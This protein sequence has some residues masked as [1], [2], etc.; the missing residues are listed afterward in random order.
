M[1]DLIF[2][3]QTVKD[4]FLHTWFY[5]LI[6]IPLAVAVQLSG[7]SRY[8]KKAFTARPIQAIFLATIV[9]AFSPFC[10]C[11]VIPVVASLLIGGVPLAPVMSFWIAS[12]SMDP[13][14]FFLSV[15]MIGWE[16]AVWRLLGTLVLSLAA[17]LITHYLVKHRLLGSEILTINNQIE[18]P[19]FTQQ[20]TKGWAFLKTKLASLRKPQLAPALCCSSESGNQIFSFTG[21]NAYFNEVAAQ[22]SQINAKTE[23]CGS[24]KEKPVKI[25]ERNSCG[26]N[27]PQKR[28]VRKKSDGCGCN[29]PSSQVE[30]QKK[31][32]CDCSKQAVSPTFRQKLLKESY[33]AVK[34]VVQFMLLAYFLEALIKLYVPSELIINSL[35]S[36]NMLAIPLA[37]LI[38]VPVYTSNLTALPLISGLLSQ[39]M[40]KGAALAFLVSGPTTTL[41]AMAAVWGLVNNRVFSLY[42][43]F[44]LFGALVLGYLFQ[45]LG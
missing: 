37:A 34:L 31:E 13:E 29:E 9:G 20:L 39:G 40:S 36:Q 5:L 45:F 21:Q 27:E 19:S 10:S 26:C 35:G 1:N 6:T 43:A 14:I 7:A 24:E 23:C 38:G 4:S 42:I 41:P 16:L 2:I 11:G 28:V 33:I 30:E 8:I 15:A 25:K 12:P 18:K 44:S 17:G 32:G 22:S 3:I